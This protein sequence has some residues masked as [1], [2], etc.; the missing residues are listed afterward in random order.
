VP[1]DTRLL[2]PKRPSGGGL[3]VD[4]ADYIRRV[5]DADKNYL[6]PI[7]RY[8]INNFV[9]GCKD[10]AIWSALKASCLLMGARTLSGAL[11][12]LVGSAP[13]NVGPFVAGDYTRGGTTPGLQGNGSTK[14]INTG[15]AGNADG[16]N[17]C[18][19]AAWLTVAH[20]AAYPFTGGADSDNQVYEYPFAGRSAFF[21]LRTTAGG[22]AGSG[23]TFVTGFRGMSRAS[24]ANYTI[25]HQNATTTITET[26][27]TPSAENWR[28]FR[29]GTR[30]DSTGDAR[31]CFYS[32]GSAL[33]LTLLE[34]RV[35]SLI[36]ALRD[37]A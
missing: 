13:T 32:I 35:S 11:T 4:A 29:S 27:T 34:S 19:F 37:V 10:D 28:V 23:N 2:I 3:D 18:H 14:A 22:S 1:L 7:V 26:S 30:T 25:R 17:D 8:A 12:P 33:T 31:I 9:R 5:E 16:Q 36:N 15:R 6:E 20:T 21:R 24:S